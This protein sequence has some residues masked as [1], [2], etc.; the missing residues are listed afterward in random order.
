MLESL[1]N[2]AV[3]LK[4]CNSI[5]IMPQHRCFPVK[6][7]KFLRTPFFTEEFLRLLLRFLT[8]VFKG[9]GAKAGATIINKY[10]IQLKKTI[11]REKPEPATVGVL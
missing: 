11:F 10:Q 5:K 3:G 4:A 9:V 6:C 7:A 2:K 8:H 1:F